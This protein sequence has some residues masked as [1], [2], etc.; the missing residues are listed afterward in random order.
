MSPACTNIFF[1]RFRLWKP[2][3]SQKKADIFHPDLGFRMVFR[4]FL[5]RTSYTAADTLTTG[6]AA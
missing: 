3:N 4:G 6:V 2:R 5:V 1:D